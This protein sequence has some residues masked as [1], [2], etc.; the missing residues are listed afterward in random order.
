MFD[1]HHLMRDLNATRTADLYATAAHDRLVRELKR[2]SSTTDVAR[3]RRPAPAV[4][5]WQRWRTALS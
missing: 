2:Q 1:N 5:W 4:R 3:V